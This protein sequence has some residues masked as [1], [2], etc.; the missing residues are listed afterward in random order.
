M[1]VPQGGAVTQ[2]PQGS[3][4]TQVPQGSAV[5]QV[6]QGSAVPQVMG[7]R[8]RDMQRHASW[9]SAPLFS[10]YKFTALWYRGV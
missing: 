2:V 6:P 8:H 1:E 3:A 10:Q 7:R 4:V 9:R 5:P